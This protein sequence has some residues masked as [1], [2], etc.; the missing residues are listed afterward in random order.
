MNQ[1][2]IVLLLLLLTVL[3]SQF[4]YAQSDTLTLGEIEIASVKNPVRFKELSRSVILVSKE[5]IE[6]APIQSV[7][8]IL[9]YYGGMDIRS[10]GPMGIQ[11]DISIRGGSFDQ[12]LIMINGVPLND[13]QTG[14]HNLNLPVM[15]QNIEKIEILEGSGARWFGANAYSGGINI[16]TTPANEN[17]LNV[18]LKGG[19]HQ[20]MG[21]ALGCNYQLG[22]ISNN[23]SAGW[24]S[25]KGYMTNTDF[26]VWQLSHQSVYTHKQ[27]SLAFQLGYLNK[28]FGANSFYTPKYPDQ[29][30]QLKNT[31]ASLN[32]EGG[33]N[34]RMKTS[35]Y[36]RRLN[37]RFE[38]F[39]ED[40]DWYIKKGDVYVNGSDTAGF[41]SPGG[42]YP[43]KGHNYHRTDVWGGE[44]SLSFSSKLGK[45]STGISFRNEHIFSNVLGL[46]MT[47]TIA[48]A[49]EADGFYTRSKARQ[50]YA[51]YLEHAV[52]AGGFTLSGGM[53]F[54]LNNDY[55]FHFSPG[56][57]LGFFITKKLKWF[58]TANKAIR[59]PTYTDLYYQG[60]DHISNPDL[61]AE[62]ALSFES[63]FKYFNGDFHASASVFYR[64]GANSID[65]VKSSVD[66]KWESQN[67]T[68]LN[69]TGV[70]L[71]AIYSNQSNPHSFMRYLGVR[72]TYLHADKN[73]GAFVSLYA[74]DYLRH[75]VNILFAH[76]ISKKFSASWTLALQQ[77]N[78]SYIDYANSRE[79]SYDFVHLFNGKV[80]Y[81]HRNLL[82]YVEASN[83]LNQKY[84]DLGNVV[85]A[86]IWIMGGV[87]IKLPFAGH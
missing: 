30:E 77:R 18:S 17:K 66:A 38:L 15:L 52:V 81:R 50:N 80:Q 61:K 41:P 24:S 9:K 58:A 42:L 83:I 76:R 28:A 35:L 39:R 36:W 49:A 3:T 6:T 12:N 46:P 19:Q 48:I 79:T 43:Y 10:R 4:I 73:A 72:Y 40:S 68:E 27:H 53:S 34:I 55:G 32:Y 85:Q 16:L 29:F 82:L 14:H 5:E 65:W 1:R 44:A 57:D 67:I 31:F 64:L 51:A 47:D 56:I 11:S 75:H 63:G 71:S 2:N 37:D 33:K 22:S 20:F 26:K 60:P 87:D 23:T 13:P 70:S 69:T 74:L 45:T 59:L 86:G 21:F 7:D 54:F 25:S 8:D 62:E 78:G 84:V